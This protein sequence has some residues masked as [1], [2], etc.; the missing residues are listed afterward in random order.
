MFLKAVDIPDGSYEGKWS[1]YQ[2]KFQCN[3]EEIVAKTV[4]GIRGINVPVK[5]QVVNQHIVEESIETFPRN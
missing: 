3:G 4:I 2:I 1:G 5:F